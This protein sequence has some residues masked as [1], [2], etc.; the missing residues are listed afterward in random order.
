M[1]IVIDNGHKGYI[2]I[3]LFICQ[4]GLE[5]YKMKK[6]FAII[7]FSDMTEISHNTHIN[8]HVNHTCVSYPP[9]PKYLVATSQITDTEA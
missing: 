6:S 7:T 9:I 2:P 4:R 3:E 1:W 8:T 5:V